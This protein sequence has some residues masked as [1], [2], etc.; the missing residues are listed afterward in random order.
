MILFFTCLGM[1]NIFRQ[2]SIE[3]EP[4]NFDKAALLILEPVESVIDTS[5]GET[6]RLHT[7]IYSYIM[8]LCTVKK[9]KE[10]RRDL[11]GGRH[12]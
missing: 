3:K 5:V 8:C 12:G 6:I 7:W 9:E 11:R 4:W 1:L 2:G 10:T